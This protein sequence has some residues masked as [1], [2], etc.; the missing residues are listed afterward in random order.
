MAEDKKTTASRAVPPMQVPI[1]GTGD[2]RGLSS[3]TEVVTP[4]AHE[5]NVVFTV[6]QPVVAIVIRFVNAY[7]TMLVGTITAGMGTSY[8]P[9]TD[10]M[11]LLSKSAIISLVPAFVGLLK[12]C[13]TIFGRLEERNPLWTG[14]V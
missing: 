10:F 3:G 7:L 11:D 13:A 14:N 1:I 4:G 2:G 6:V 12:D 9:F 8:I 5:P